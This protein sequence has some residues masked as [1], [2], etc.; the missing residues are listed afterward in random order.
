MTEKNIA[1]KIDD[2]TQVNS[3]SQGVVR[4]SWNPNYGYAREQA[5]N[6]A[7]VQAMEDHAL[8]QA[9][10]ND[11]FNTQRFLMMEGA[12]ADLQLRLKILEGK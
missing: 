11:V 9:E 8:Q 10:R 7:R 2:L 1:P 12:I 4:S 5:I 6:E 3:T